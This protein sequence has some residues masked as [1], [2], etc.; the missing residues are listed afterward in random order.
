MNEHP[1]ARIPASLRHDSPAGRK[2]RG[3]TDPRWRAVTWAARSLSVTAAAEPPTEP[4]YRTAVTS[5][6]AEAGHRRAAAPTEIASEG[7][8]DA[9]DLS[10]TRH[11]TCRHG[12]SLGRPMHFL[13]SS[14]A[15]VKPATAVPRRGLRRDPRSL[16]G[17]RWRPGRWW[18]TTDVP[19]GRTRRGTSA[20]ELES[21]ADAD[22]CSTPAAA[23]A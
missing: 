8:A 19:C 5:P 12:P 13:I 18:N 20:W 11:R 21:I 10:A 16:G 14:A 17:P 6:L 15:A 9:R 4:R 1:G 22:S 2:R 7:A 3:S 23:R